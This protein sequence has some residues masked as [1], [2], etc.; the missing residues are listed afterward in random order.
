VQRPTDPALS[1]RDKDMADDD[2]LRELN[3]VRAENARLRGL[4]GLDGRRA[5][6]HAQSWEPSLFQ[7]APGLPQVDGRSSSEE[8]LGLY[9]RLFAGRTDVFALR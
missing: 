2:L 9:Q 7:D 1:E 8:K 4:L 3:E 6:T 5:E